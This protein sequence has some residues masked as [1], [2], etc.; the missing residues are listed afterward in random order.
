MIIGIGMGF[1]F[2]SGVGGAASLPIVISDKF[3]RADNASSLGNADTGQTWTA[4]AGTWGI[5]SNRAYTPAGTENYAVIDSGI[6]NLTAEVTLAVRVN[7]SGIVFRFTDSA[8]WYRFVLSS[9]T[10]FLQRRLANATTSLS[11][12]A[13]T[14][15]DGDV[16]KV[17]VNGS[18]FMAY[19]NGELKA[20][21]ND[22][23]FPT[24]TWVGM[25]SAGSSC[26][27]DNFKVEA[28]L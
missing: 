6:L 3:D 7:R 16:L 13:V 5:Q 12:F 24:Q 22:T 17:V 21:V 9:T 11:S 15:A 28:I 19:Y 8:N 18:Q 23:T 1:G 26:R 27:L 2:N 25:E 20:T 14:P 4:S 10:V